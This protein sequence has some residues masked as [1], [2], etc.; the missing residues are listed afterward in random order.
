METVT[1]L[2]TGPWPP[3]ASERTVIVART[4]Q[5]PQSREVVAV[6]VAVVAY[7]VVM[8]VGTRPPPPPPPKPV[9]PVKPRSVNVRVGVHGAGAVEPGD[10]IRL[11]RS[12]RGRMRE[13]GERGCGGAWV[14]EQVEVE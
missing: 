5:A 2:T 8:R 9:K 7:A 14:V 3:N 12:R 13:G 1:T 4:A 11:A 10:R 6:A